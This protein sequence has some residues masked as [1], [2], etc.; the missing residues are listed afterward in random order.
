MNWRPENW[1]NPYKEPTQSHY[2]DEE[3]AYE[4]GADAMLEAIHAEI[5]KVENPEI[6]M[7]RISADIRAYVRRLHEYYQLG[8]LFRR[9]YADLITASG[10][11]QAETDIAIH[12]VAFGMMRHK[13]LALFEE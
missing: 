10:A 13:I 12:R 11:I 4:A 1:Q 5:E 9:E 2:W 3:S 8:Y 6:R 7:E